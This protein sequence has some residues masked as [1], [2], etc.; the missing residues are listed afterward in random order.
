MLLLA[1]TAILSGYFLPWLPH[2]AAGLR[3]IGLEMGE[4]VKF[5]PQVRSGEISARRDWFY[6]PPVTLGLALALLS[7][8]WPNGRWQTWAMRT[9]ALLVS[10]LAFPALEAVRQE[11]ADNYLLRLQLV[12]LVVLVTTLSSLGRYWPPYLAWLLLVVVG[13]A[14][15]A[16]PTWIYLVVRPAISQVLGTAVAVGPGVWLNLSGHGLI[17]AV[18]LSVLWHGRRLAVEKKTTPLSGGIVS[19]G[20]E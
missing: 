9:L 16:V 7:A 11:S 6:L 14:G 1:L 13:L 3:L 10:L 20:S 15:A 12:G 8:R 2:P 5:L 4:W 19:P 18:T 17:V